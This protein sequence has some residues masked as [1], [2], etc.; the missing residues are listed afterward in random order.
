M[1]TIRKIVVGLLLGVVAVCCAYAGSQIDDGKLKPP[2]PLMP[3]ARPSD[4]PP[5]YSLPE[6]TPKKQAPPSQ[7]VRPVAPWL[8]TSQTAKTASSPA[9]GDSPSIRVQTITALSSPPAANVKVIGAREPVYGMLPPASNVPAQQEK[10]TV[11]EVP[12]TFSPDMML[13]PSLPAPPTSLTPVSAQVDAVKPPTPPSPP[14]KLAARQ[15]KTDKPLTPPTKA[16]TDKVAPPVPA[17]PPPPP[18][19]ASGP[20]VPVPP[21]VDAVK[22]PTLPA[23]PEPVVPPSP[24][25]KT[26]ASQAKTD[27]LLT[28]PPRTDADK[29][30][31][32]A[33]AFPP[34]PEKAS[35]PEVPVP[36]RVDAVKL[37]TMPASPA[38]LVPPSPPEK[39]AASRAEI[40][41]A[42]V[43]P[44]AP[45]VDSTPPPDFPRVPS[46]PAKDGPSLTLPAR[47]DGPAPMLPVRPSV[48]P[49]KGPSLTLPARKDG[50][51]LTLPARKD[52]PSLTLPARTEADAVKPMIRYTGTSEPSTVQE[53][54]GPAQPPPAFTLVRPAQPP[55]AP[56]AA[57]PVVTPQPPP[58]LPPPA[59]DSSLPPPSDQ[60]IPLPPPATSLANL[61]DD[62]RD[63]SVPSIQNTDTAKGNRGPEAPAAPEPPAVTMEKLGPTAMK[64]G[65]RLSFE[66]VLRNT[67]TTP[68]VEVRVEDQIPAGARLLRAEP[69]PFIKGANLSWTVGV[70]PAGVEKRFKL[71]MQASSSGPC[72]TDLR[73]ISA[74]PPDRPEGEQRRTGEGEKESIPVPAVAPTRTSDVSISVHGPAHA[75]PGSEVIFDIHVMNGTAQPLGNPTLFVAF[76]A[77]L[78]HPNGAKIEGDLGDLPA[79]AQ[80]NVQL[81]VK[82]VRAGLQ[83]IDCS[84]LIGGAVRASAQAR[85]VLG[86]AGLQVL[87]NPSHRL[88]VGQPNEIRFEVANTSAQTLKYVAVSDRL[89]DGVEVVRVSD[90]GVYRSGLQ[91]V[92][93]LLD[94]SPGQSRTLTVQVQP[95]QNGDWSNEVQAKIS[96]IPEVRSSAVVHAEGYANVTFKIVGADAQ[97]E[98][99]KETIYKICVTNHGTAPATNVLIKA[100]VSEGLAIGHSQGPTSFRTQGSQITFDPLPRLEPDAHQIFTVG[101]VAQ[102]Q[103]DRR[104]RVHLS[105]DQSPI[106]VSQEQRALVYRN[107]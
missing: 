51:S 20:E 3:P 57:K 39:P 89:P 6:P 28:P 44:V 41:K 38:P 56:P 82:A 87:Q 81:R 98:V 43:A 11:P 17:F 9:A 99:G 1:Q 71:Q 88:L 5:G 65:Q 2:P 48:E 59:T 27:K 101:V 19:K 50:P 68:A 32:P 78:K 75:E 86:K 46:P 69:M 94:L 61:G 30:A 60:G 55:V 4:S 96:G 16:D 42:P 15:T 77:G 97:L 18:E 8:E 63:A 105:S 45:D 53:P 23:S 7:P 58:T 54:S 83:R 12:A 36:P 73:V 47:T 34:S 31:P 84:V 37:P 24:P 40:D 14:E 85:I 76:S 21:P 106:P 52:G 70:L 13:P 79:G 92:S 93:W 29:V 90:K 91:T 26:A 107:Q 35:S 74:A 22:L 25:E 67:G 66:I 104:F 103:G 33:P 95:K 64:A 72:T 49:K 62:R 10:V 80:K 102:S 100:N